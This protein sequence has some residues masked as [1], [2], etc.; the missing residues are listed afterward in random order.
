ME[1]EDDEERAWGGSWGAGGEFGRA[2]L[3]DRDVA[4]IL[5]SHPFFQHF[6]SEADNQGLRPVPHGTA[7]TAEAQLLSDEEH[8]DLFK[9]IHDD[10][11]AAAL[12]LA[13]G[14]R[15]LK[16]IQH[17]LSPFPSSTS[18]LLHAVIRDWTARSAPTL[19]M[20]KQQHQVLSHIA[21][22]RQSHI[23]VQ[24]LANAA[25]VPMVALAAEM[26]EEGVFQLFLSMTR[27][28]LDIVLA[29]LKDDQRM[30]I[31]PLPT[32]HHDP[33]LLSPAST[34]SA[35]RSQSRSPAPQDQPHSITGRDLKQ[36]FHVLEALSTSSEIAAFTTAT[37]QSANAAERAVAAVKQH[38]S[39]LTG[40]TPTRLALPCWD[41]DASVLVPSDSCQR[42][43]ES[44]RPAHHR[45]AST[46]R[47]QQHPSKKQPQ[48][49]PPKQPQNQPPKQPQ[50]QPQDQQCRV[51]PLVATA[52]LP[53]RAAVLALLEYYAE[54]HLHLHQSAHE[55]ADLSEQEAAMQ[56][57]QSAR[58]THPLATPTAPI[59]AAHTPVLPP[60]HRQQQQ[61]DENQQQPQELE[62]K[63][64]YTF[65]LPPQLTAFFSCSAHTQGIVHRHTPSTAVQGH[66]VPVHAAPQPGYIGD[67]QRAC[68]VCEGCQH[69]PTFVFPEPV[70]LCGYPHV[71]WVLVVTRPVLANVSPRLALAKV[72]ARIT[73]CMASYPATQGDG[74]VVFSLYP[75]TRD[76]ASFLASIPGTPDRV[77]WV[78]FFPQLKRKSSHDQPAHNSGFSRS[79]NDTIAAPDTKSGLHFPLVGQQQQQQQ[80]H[81]QQQPQ[82]KKPSPTTPAP[83]SPAP[84]HAAGLLQDIQSSGAHRHTPLRHSTRRRAE[85]MFRDNASAAAAACLQFASRVLDG[86]SRPP[87]PTPP[88][89]PPPPSPSSR[90]SRHPVPAHFEENKDHAALLTGDAVW[91][92]ALCN[93]DTASS[94]VAVLLARYLDPGFIHTALQQQLRLHTRATDGH[95]C[96]D[97]DGRLHSLPVRV[98]GPGG[99]QPLHEALQPILNR[100]TFADSSMHRSSVAISSHP[101][102]HVSPTGGHTRR[103]RLG[104]AASALSA[105][106]LHSGVKQSARRAHG[107]IGDSGAGGG[108]DHRHEEDWLGDGLLGKVNAASVLLSALEVALGAGPAGVAPA[109]PLRFAFLQWASMHDKH[110]P[111]VLPA[112]E[113]RVL[114]RL[115]NPAKHTDPTA[116]LKDA[117]NALRFVQCLHVCSCSPLS[118]WHNSTHTG[119]Q[120]P[121]LGSRG[122]AR[123]PAA[124]SP[125]FLLHLAKQLVAQL[126][127]AA[128]NARDAELPCEP[129][130]AV[131]VLRHGLLHAPHV[132]ETT[133]ALLHSTLKPLCLHSAR[134][135]RPTLDV[136]EAVEALAQNPMVHRLGAATRTIHV[137]VDVRDGTGSA[138]RAARM[139]Q[140][141]GN[142]VSHEAGLRCLLFDCFQVCTRVCVWVC[143]WV[144]VALVHMHACV[145]PSLC[146]CEL[147]VLTPFLE[148]THACRR[149]VEVKARR[150]QGLREP[151]L[152]HQTLQSPKAA[153]SW[154]T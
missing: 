130:Q 119:S 89:P 75:V 109:P 22:M 45:D 105:L 136:L 17:Y 18:A 63:L 112:L 79:I 143:V 25:H 52:R 20:Q 58:T 92:E 15:G 154:S 141:A 48:K 104:S 65:I 49:H 67:E 31:P 40:L 116:V 131:H 11:L 77:G 135:A 7:P 3:A 152:L 129:L 94:L 34:A 84:H 44:Q 10:K 117:S 93:A 14:S 29:S 122:K 102:D 60:Q 28:Q 146:F 4:A 71:K 85:A 121:Q 134:L 74:L 64:N 140:L 1:E 86:H 59:G 114:K 96:D 42:S 132:N 30:P 35:S 124:A 108:N 5:T 107:G 16:Y 153:V 91:S 137:I 90:R 126:S 36:R 76:V 87:P 57:Q 56:V 123:H 110:K 38:L 88:S 125:S 39:H 98:V 27:Q 139:L 113:E 32:Q 69:G 62:A 103:Q 21:Q 68:A 100:T 13:L 111:P 133:L 101:M 81:Q 149:T 120:Q 128:Q 142:D 54:R 127:P 144:C 2:Q 61:E 97:S 151:L 72:K 9:D 138:E 66:A 41:N 55:A 6:Y 19:V 145:S 147:L 23:P 83:A 70:A 115:A 37:M 33:L 118:S 50:Q 82:R 46:S 51:P 73:M 47:P 12:H 99:I 80:Q 24:A 78:C 8:E 150:W 43:H 26:I 148:H 106:P 53:M 95:G